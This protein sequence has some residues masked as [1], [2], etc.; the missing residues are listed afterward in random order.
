[1]MQRR[2]G[3]IC[4]DFVLT[5]ANYKGWWKA[6]EKKKLQYASPTITKGI[7]WSNATKRAQNYKSIIEMKYYTEKKGKKQ[8]PKQMFAYIQQYIHS[9]VFFHIFAV[10][11]T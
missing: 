2:E 7:S 8:T 3:G 1:M 10:V 9:T 6:R 11:H 4:E 5:E